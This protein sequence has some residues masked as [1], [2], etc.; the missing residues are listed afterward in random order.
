VRVL[1][2]GMSGTGKSAVVKELRRRGHT[3]YDADDDGYSEPGVDG[4]WRW[5][6]DA[7]ADLLDTSDAGVLFFAGCSEEQ[8]VFTWDRT[9]VLTAPEPVI[10]RRLRDRTGNP[11]GKS[12]RERQ[13]ILGD[14]RDV[15]PRLRR[16]ATAVIDATQPLATVVAEILAISG[17]SFDDQRQEGRR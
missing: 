15:E 10:V 12:D 16:S 5:R 6:V 2:T 7:V 13:K 14:L 11:F 3:A 17:T 8:A 4:A 1:I 9:I